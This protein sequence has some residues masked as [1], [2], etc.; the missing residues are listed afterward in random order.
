MELGRTFFDCVSRNF[1]GVFDRVCVSVFVAAASVKTAELTIGDTDICVV[2]M[3]VDVVIRI[4]AVPLAP[5]MIGEFAKRVQIIGL[6]KRHPFIKC[7]AFVGKNL[8]GDF[9]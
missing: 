2:K 1:Y 7:E 6:I 5:H 8:F 4:F 3:A 9:V